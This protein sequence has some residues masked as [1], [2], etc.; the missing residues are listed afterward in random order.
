MPNAIH[1]IAT[2]AFRVI[3]VIAKAKVREWELAQLRVKVPV[4][5]GLSRATPPIRATSVFQGSPLWEGWQATVE[6]GVH[7]AR[8]KTQPRA[9]ATVSIFRPQARSLVL[10]IAYFLLSAIS[11]LLVIHYRKLN[12]IY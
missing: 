4:E 7:G 3:Q 8:L 5:W 11:L 6:A 1:P 12:Y 9:F 2:W 10:P